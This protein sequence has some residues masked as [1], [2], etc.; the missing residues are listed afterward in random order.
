[1]PCRELEPYRQFFAALNFL[2]Y[3][4]RYRGNTDKICRHRKNIR[5]EL[6]DVMARV[7]GISRKLAAYHVAQMEDSELL[8]RLEKY[9]EMELSAA[10]PNPRGVSVLLPGCHVPNDDGRLDGTQPHSRAGEDT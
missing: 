8:W 3:G 2:S 1:M 5:Q 4:K 7:H 10:G 9:A 6:R